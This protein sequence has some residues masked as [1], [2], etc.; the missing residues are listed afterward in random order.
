MT[1]FVFYLSRRSV[2]IISYCDAHVVIIDFKQAKD[3][4]WGIIQIRETHRVRE[5][6]KKCSMRCVMHAGMF[7]FQGVDVDIFTTREIGN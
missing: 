5:K 1:L 2:E 3:Q 6:L 4:E 7:L